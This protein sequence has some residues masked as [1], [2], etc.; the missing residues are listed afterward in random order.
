MDSDLEPTASLSSPSV[1]HPGF[2]RSRSRDV[3]A[4]ADLLRFSDQQVH[5]VYQ[6]HQAY[7]GTPANR[8]LTIQTGTPNSSLLD[9]SAHQAHVEGMQSQALGGVGNVL[10]RSGGWFPFTAS[11]DAWGHRSL[12]N[13]GGVEPAYKLNEV[14]MAVRICYKSSS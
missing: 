11:Q 10:D 6:Q 1:E 4:A 8:P 2:G 13:F 7:Q 3:A 5:L 14:D 9:F 12:M